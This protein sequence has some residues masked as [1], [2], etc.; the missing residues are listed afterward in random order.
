MEPLRTN[1]MLRF[2][3]DLS[4]GIVMLGSVPPAKANRDA[5]ATYRAR[6]TLHATVA[7]RFHC[8]DYCAFNCVDTGVR[9]LHIRMGY[10]G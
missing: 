2:A 10:S 1:V 5:K 9:C 3:C 4:L 8:H 6:P 7:I